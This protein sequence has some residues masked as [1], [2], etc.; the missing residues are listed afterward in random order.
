MISFPFNVNETTKSQLTR[1]ESEGVNV[2][3]DI[4]SVQ[5]GVIAEGDGAELEWIFSE[6]ISFFVGEN[7]VELTSHR[8]AISKALEHSQSTSSIPKVAQQGPMCEV[9]VSG[10]D[11]ELLSSLSKAGWSVVLELDPD[12]GGLFAVYDSRT[13]LRWYFIS[14][15]RLVGDGTVSEWNDD[16]EA[17]NALCV[18]LETMRTGTQSN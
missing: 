1:L 3:I 2:M 4:D 6:Y 14:E 18:A 5:G 9:E 8:D 17:I 12:H 16:G 10:D 11:F 13:Y 15:I 7:E